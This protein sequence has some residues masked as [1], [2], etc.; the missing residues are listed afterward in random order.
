MTVATNTVGRRKVGSIG[1]E[2]TSSPEPEI[3]AF[4]PVYARMPTRQ[5]GMPRAAW[6]LVP[7]LIL[8]AGL[9]TV[10]LTNRQPKVADEAPMTTPASQ[11]ALTPAQASPSSVPMA[12]AVTP[13]PKVATETT[14]APTF[15]A[16]ARRAAST[17]VQAKAPLMNKPAAVLPE[18]P[19]AYD[20]NAAAPAQNSVTV[21]AEVP[22][23]PADPA[24]GPI[25]APLPTPEVLTIPNF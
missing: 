24:P 10:V 13:V 11:V 17:R 20:G 22:S 1:F 18:A 5:A 3:T 14:A 8:A 19:M 16:P 7:T 6:M 23:Q 15:A 12:L 4:T 2:Q 21:P 25:P 9:T